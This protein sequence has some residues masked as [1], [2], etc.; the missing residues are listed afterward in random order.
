MALTDKLTAIGN[1]IR[2]KTGGTAALTLPEMAAAVSAI[3]TGI[4]NCVTALYHNATAKGG[5]GSVTLMSG[6]SFIAE[7]YNNAKAFALVVKI[8]GLRSNGL[9]MLICTNQAFGVLSTSN[10]TD[11]FG[12]FGTNSETVTGAAN[13]ITKPLGEQSTT[14]G[15][16]Y[17]TASGD[18][19]IRHG[20]GSNAFQTGDYFIIFGVM[21][22]N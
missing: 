6:N 12:W 19:V 3:P 16:M 15:H 18:L 13:R 11:V 4:T 21:E 5:G 20:S 1:A 9:D 7:N 22:S 17:A 8:S 14:V 10:N 2:A